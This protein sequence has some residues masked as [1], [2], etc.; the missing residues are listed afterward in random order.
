MYSFSPIGLPLKASNHHFSHKHAMHELFFYRLNFVS[1]M[2][3]LVQIRKN[4]N[5]NVYNLQMVYK[6]AHPIVY[7]NYPQKSLSNRLDDNITCSSSNWR[8]TL[9]VGKVQLDPHFG[10]V[11]FQ[12]RHLHILQARFYTIHPEWLIDLNNKLINIIIF[13]ILKKCI[14]SD[15][16][17]KQEGF[18]R[19]YP[20]SIRH[21]NLLK[22]IT[23]LQLRIFI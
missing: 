10:K 23:I 20:T 14:P 16:V 7:R 17:Y 1:Q 13:L 2:K 6:K 22:I 3:H 11:N 18:T 5:K 15:K 21:S 4:F 19:N 9:S 12:L 8:L